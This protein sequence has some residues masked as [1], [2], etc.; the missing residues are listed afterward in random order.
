MFFTFIHLEQMIKMCLTRRS[1]LRPAIRNLYTYVSCSSL[2]YLPVML[3][4]NILVHLIV[5]V[6]WFQQ[7]ISIDRVCVFVQMT[8][9]ILEH[10]Y[11][12][13]EIRRPNSVVIH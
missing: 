2:S 12:L 7:F 9:G 3:S 10:W 13:K 4:P 8:I 6:S 11:K 5:C 1:A